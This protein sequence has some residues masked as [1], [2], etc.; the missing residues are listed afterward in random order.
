MPRA[1]IRVDLHLGA[2]DDHYRASVT[3]LPVSVFGKYFSDS[4]PGSLAPN[5]FRTDRYGR[6]SRD[7]S[8]QSYE[9]R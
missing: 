7:F 9:G 2:S 8:L 6:D 5:L 3:F 4:R 1:V